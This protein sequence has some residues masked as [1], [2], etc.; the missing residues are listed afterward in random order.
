[1]KKYLL[2]VLFF[3]FVLAWCQTKTVAPIDVS[4]I[5]DLSSLDLAISQVYQDI[6]SW[7]LSTDQALDIVNKLQQKYIDLTTTTENTIETKFETIQKKFNELSVPV[8]WLPL[9]AKRLWVTEPVGM[10]LN[11]SLST[12]NVV[13]ISGYSSTVLVYSWT[14]D[15]ALQQANDIAKKAHLSVSK[16]FQQAQ[17]LAK[18]G[19]IDYISGLDIGSLSKWIVYTNHE[20]LDTNVD[21]L[22]SVSVDQ[23]WTLTIETTKYQN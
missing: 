19:N 10:E 14:Y 8:Y 5:N 4:A 21:K 20:L 15:V 1:M 12:F 3:F 2:L 18:L 6:S 13:N 7:T 23:Y 11:K 17:S 9:W 16:N 22:L